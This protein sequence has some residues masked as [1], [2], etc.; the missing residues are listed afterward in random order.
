M[1]RSDRRITP[2]MFGSADSVQQKA[3]NTAASLALTSLYSLTILQVY[4]GDPDAITLLD[5]LKACY[6]KFWKQ[7]D[8][9]LEDDS[10]AS[11]VLV[12]V[13]LTFVSKQSKL[14]ARMS[15]QVF[16]AFCGEID[17]QALQL[18]ADVRSYLNTSNLVFTDHSIG[19]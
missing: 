1:A 19:S 6:A 9:K 7:K 13:V 8:S 4:N 2:F 11:K 14:F 15:E 3:Q 10:E 17:S 16:A 18:L 12:E 5:E